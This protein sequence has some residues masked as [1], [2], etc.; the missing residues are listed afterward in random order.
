MNRVPSLLALALLTVSACSYRSP[1]PPGP[2]IG[3]APNALNTEIR[4]YAPEG[5]NTFKVDDSVGL[6]IE[7]VGPGE[8]LFRSDYGVEV[9]EYTEGEWREV[10]KVPGE[11]GDDLVL[12]PSG[13]D[14]LG[15]GA[16]SVFPVLPDTSD[17]V[18]LRIF[19]RGVLVVEGQATGDEV[20]AFVDVTLQP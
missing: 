11:S 4:V 9:Y 16:T 6:A 5:W 2:D 3:I 19:V 1:A 12:G 15:F 20:G 14:P 8:V 7:V 17:P 13:G 18:M 10:P